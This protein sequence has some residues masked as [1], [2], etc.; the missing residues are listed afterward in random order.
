M[1][2]WA[3]ALIGLL[4]GLAIEGRD[5]YMVLKD[6][7]KPAPSWKAILGAFILRTC[8]GAILGGV[9]I[10]SNPKLNAIIVFIG[11][12]SGLVLIDKFTQ[13]AGVVISVIGAA[14]GGAAER[15]LAA[16]SPGTAAAIDTVSQSGPDKFKP[17]SA[18]GQRLTNDEGIPVQREHNE[19]DRE[20]AKA[21]REEDSGHVEVSS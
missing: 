18:V 5:H 2:I 12:V 8:I 20:G 7:E 3:G 4:G 11:G 21:G 15:A 9:L 14:I 16:L 6:T 19:T 1:P 13:G 10:A 17:T